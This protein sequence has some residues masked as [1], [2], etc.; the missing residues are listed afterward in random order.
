MVFQKPKGT[1][2][3]FPEDKELQNQ[4]FTRLKT[5]AK[6]YNFKEVEGPAIENLEVLTKKEGEEIKQQI[7]T[8]EKRGDERFGLRFD[9]TVPNARMFI[10]KQKQIS[11]PV[12]WF[13]I[14]KVWRYE[15]P[16]QGRLREFYQFNAELF[17]S[18]KPESDAEV[19]SLA[20]DLLLNL[21]LTKKDFIVRINNRRLLESILLNFVEKE[22]VEDLFVV[23][24]KK[25]KVLET[26]FDAE[27]KKIIKDSKKITELKNILK[28]SE[29]NQLK[30]NKN[31]KNKKE[32]EDG[33]NE[34]ENILQL[35]KNKKEFVKIDLSTARGLAYYT[36]TVFEI[37]DSKGNFRSICGGGRYDN[38]VA[39]LGGEKTPATGFAIGYATLK[40]LLEER[41]LLPKIE[42]GCDYYVIIVSEKV[43]RDALE[44]AEKLRK[45]YIV[46]TDLMQRKMQKQLDYANSI[47]AKKV[48]FVGEDEIKSGKLTVK[49]MKTGKQEKISLKELLS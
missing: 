9:F 14:D 42:L 43:K 39:L 49:D 37:Y 8:L 28:I 31:I 3:Y 32:V 6:S 7:F 46:D 33:I 21:G 29:L 23:I 34:L 35:L 10:E 20:I 19:I 26:E 17:G 4:I 24:D 5:I 2:D 36:S 1:V 47:G 16:Q 13:C 12:K 30:N 38:L 40:L 18:D 41:G 22:K 11:K 27:L 45:R 48:I 15:R 25:N 44:I